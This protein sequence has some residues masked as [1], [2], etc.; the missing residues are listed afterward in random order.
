MLNFFGQEP[1][2]F[3]PVNIYVTYHIFS[4]MEMVYFF[5]SQYFVNLTLNVAFSLRSLENH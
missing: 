2:I 3:Y 4:F 5:C 1:M